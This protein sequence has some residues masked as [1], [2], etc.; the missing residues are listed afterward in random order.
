MN[1]Q[2]NKSFSGSRQKFVVISAGCILT[3]SFVDDPFFDVTTTLCFSRL[4]IAGTGV[5]PKP[6]GTL[7]IE[8]GGKLIMSKKTGG[9]LTFRKKYAILKELGYGVTQPICG[10]L[11]KP[12]RLFLYRWILA[13]CLFLCWW[14]NCPCHLVWRDKWLSDDMAVSWSITGTLM[15]MIG[16]PRFLS[17]LCH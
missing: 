17:I 4:V 2:C 15:I 5:C 7:L 13:P 10:V 16:W 9:V 8:N 1:N 14:F 3:G 12:A 11:G 6:F